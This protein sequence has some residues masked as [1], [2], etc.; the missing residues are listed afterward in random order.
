[1]LYGQALAAGRY[2]L[3]IEGQNVYVNNIYAGYNMRRSE[4][5][6]PTLPQSSQTYGTMKME[7]GGIAVVATNG[8]GRWYPNAREVKFSD[9]V[10]SGNVEGTAGA[11]YRLYRAAFGRKPDATAWATRW[12]RWKS[13]A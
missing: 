5:A 2:V 1:M 13:W 11:V 4:S 10:L 6:N 8:F 7:Q 3:L 9:V 12:P